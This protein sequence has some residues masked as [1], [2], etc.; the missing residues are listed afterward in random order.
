M[1]AHMS[2]SNRILGVI[3]LLVVLPL[4]LLTAA[5]PVS[6]AAATPVIQPGVALNF[7]PDFCTANFVYDG[8]GN[9]YLGSARHCTSGTSGVGSPV[10]LLTDTTVGSTVET[11]GHVAY[12][13]D[14]LDFCLIQL[15][16][17]VLGQVSAAVAGHPDMPTGVAT[18]EDAKGGDTLQFSGHG[19]GFDATTQTQQQ[20]TGLLSFFESGANQG[21]YTA[22]GAVS[23]GDSGGP[24]VDTTDGNRALGI[25][26]DLGAF[27]DGPSVGNLDGVTV[28]ALLEDAAAHGFTISL[29][30]V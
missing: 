11:I 16:S 4:A 22:L 3:P 30:T 26:D 19:L 8:G 20:R 21:L 29:R 15:D 2:T 28:Q 27:A 18:P 1:L 5:L 7:G 25:L 13:S 14:A 9:V 24:A 10:S 12:I 6:A 17:G 23:P